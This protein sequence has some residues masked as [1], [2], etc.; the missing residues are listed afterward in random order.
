[1]LEKIGSPGFETLSKTDTTVINHLNIILESNPKP[2]FY[3]IGIGI[4]ATTLPVAEILNN[5]GQIILFSRE[6]D[7][8][9]LSKDLADRGFMNVD[10]SWGSQNKIYSGYH[11]ELAMGA[12]EQKLP[13]FDIA[14]IDGGHVF[15]LDA[16]AT[17]IL[18]ELCKPGGYMI[19]DDW[20]WSL[21]ISPTLTPS[22][23]PATLQEYDMRQIEA[24]HVQLV[25]KTLM[26]TDDRFQFIGLE[27]NTAIY[28]RID[29]R[30]KL[31]WFKSL[32]FKLRKF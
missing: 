20:N 9:E 7:V 19:F 1:M 5:N 16:P 17:C 22:N 8:R 26:D 14:Y 4:G 29:K 25:C 27:G 28:Q 32:A 11:F 24:C 18:K 10:S 3:E 21:A 30:T 31:S 2:V 15:H 12:F 6:N 23:R 13:K